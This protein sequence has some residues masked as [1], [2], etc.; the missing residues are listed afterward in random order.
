[1]N[2]VPWRITR[3]KRERYVDVGYFNLTGQR[4][5][6]IVGDGHDGL[7]VGCDASLGYVIH[8]SSVDVSNLNVNKHI[9]LF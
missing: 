4:L 8:H 5:A 2:Y 1:M 6:I 7:A 9:T 3:S